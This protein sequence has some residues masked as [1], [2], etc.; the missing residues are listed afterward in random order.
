MAHGAA[1]ALGHESWEFVERVEPGVGILA[2]TMSSMTASPTAR[3]GPA[4]SSR[5]ALKNSG[6]TSSFATI[7]APARRVPPGPPTDQRRVT[8]GD[9]IGGEISPKSVDAS[10]TGLVFAQNMMYRHTM[11]V[12]A[13]TPAQP[14]HSHPR[15]VRRRDQLG[16]LIHEYELAA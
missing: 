9:S 3:R 10:D 12:L 7:V 4:T 16:R 13:A 6:V 15:Y 2:W 14:L 5:R 1:P 8:L 11:T